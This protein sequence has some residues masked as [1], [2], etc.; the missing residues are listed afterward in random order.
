MKFYAYLIKIIEICIIQVFKILHK[1]KSVYL[2]PFALYGISVSKYIFLWWLSV[3]AIT[4]RW[5]WSGLD[6]FWCASEYGDFRCRKTLPLTAVV[7]ICVVFGFI[8]AR[9]CVS[10]LFFKNLIDCHITLVQA[11]GSIEFT[12]LS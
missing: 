5:L 9:E 2:I 8:A 12:S 3:V 6:F 7:F 1:Y 11:R 10:F 4:E